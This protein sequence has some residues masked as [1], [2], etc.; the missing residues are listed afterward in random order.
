M[1]SDATTAANVSTYLAHRAQA[2]A[3]WRGWRFTQ[4]AKQDGGG[5]SD[6]PAPVRRP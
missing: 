5:R 2:P 3:D 6:P 1:T 4:D